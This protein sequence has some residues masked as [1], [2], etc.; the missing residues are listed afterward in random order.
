MASSEI[1]SKQNQTNYV[2]CIALASSF[3]MLRVG[4][5]QLLEPSF[6]IVGEAANDLE[7]IKLTTQLQP[8][9]LVTVTR[10]FH[11]EGLALVRH[12][13]TKTPHI[14]S[15]VLS[16][17][18]TMV[19]M[20]QVVHSGAHGYVSQLDDSAVLIKSINVVASGDYY[21]GNP[22]NTAAYTAWLADLALATKL[23]PAN[24]TPREK[25]IMQL[26]IEGNTSLQISNLL[27]LSIWAVNIQRNRI[28]QKSGLANRYS[29][30]QR[31][32][33]QPH[34]HLKPTD[35]GAC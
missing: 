2:P 9:V 25:E 21:F 19:D 6:T 32:R 28:R 33:Q 7:A 16:L 13:R 1:N 15:I 11:Q 14:K 30:L 35:G 4:I 23:L 29:L 3:T 22:L 24:L 18:D 8:D 17:D 34:Q 10:T 26:V 12:L 27:N 31:I 5:R 20:M